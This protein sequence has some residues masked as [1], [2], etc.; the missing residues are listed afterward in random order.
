M[1]GMA[2][3]FLGIVIPRAHYEWHAEEMVCEFLGVLIASAHCVVSS[4]KNSEKEKLHV[5]LMGW[6]FAKLKPAFWESTL[7]GL[8]PQHACITL[9]SFLEIWLNR[10][11]LG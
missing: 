11:F 6:E 7:L 10:P 1:N 9:T 8:I 3:E 5:L 4:D 2:C